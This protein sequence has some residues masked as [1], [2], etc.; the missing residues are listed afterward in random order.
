M[1]V[2]VGSANYQI[3]PLVGASKGKNWSRDTK[4]DDG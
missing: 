2:S 4:S 1:T 3:T